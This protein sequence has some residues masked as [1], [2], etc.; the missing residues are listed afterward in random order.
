LRASSPR[1][2]R[3]TGK[4]PAFYL[5]QSTMAL[6]PIMQTG[7]AGIQTGLKGLN[8]TAQDIA[9]LNLDDR[10]K[11]TSDGATIRHDKP[12]DELEGAAEAIVDLKVHKRQIEASAKVVQTADAVLGF[13]LDVR[14]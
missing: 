6:N 1:R 14:A 4:L 5:D 13:L 8:R 3:R 9:D 2:G 10:A 12:T 11:P 7:L